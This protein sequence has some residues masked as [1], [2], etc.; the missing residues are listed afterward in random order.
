MRTGNPIF[1]GIALFILV[2]ATACQRP[3]DAL[4]HQMQELRKELADLKAQEAQ[5]A[6]NQKKIQVK[7]NYQSVHTVGGPHMQSERERHSNALPVVKVSPSP[8]YQQPP[9]SWAPS[10][11]VAKALMPKKKKKGTKKDKKKREDIALPPP[12]IPPMVFQTLDEYGQVH[13]QSHAPAEHTP[14][15]TA[16]F[17]AIVEETERD[18]S[19]MG[20]N[21]PIDAPELIAMKPRAPKS[22]PVKPSWEAREPSPVPVRAPEPAPTLTPETHPMTLVSSAQVSRGEQPTLSAAEHLYKEGM[23]ALREKKYK[24]AG[25]AF[26]TLLNESPDD[27]LADNALYWMGEANYDQGKFNDALVLF[28]DVLRKYPLGNKVPDA[29]VKVGLCFQ[30]LG[31]KKQARQILE[32]VIAIYPD[33]QA[34]NVAA[35]R[36][37]TM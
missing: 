12:E 30:N 8:R 10:A 34:A 1:W 27:G 6:E 2:L 21:R 32:Q 14:P 31:K 7:D 35:S 17:E 4:V 3:N 24:K 25:S 19:V 11:P 9:K 18:V 16:Q 5:Q 33:S 28:Q 22:A 37:P 15:Q 36:L 13:G 20:S 26:Q 23:Q 29:M